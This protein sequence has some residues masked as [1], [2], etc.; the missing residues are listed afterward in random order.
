MENRTPPR[1]CGAACRRYLLLEGDISSRLEISPIYEISPPGEGDISFRR[2]Y[3]LG[4]RR[5]LLREEISPHLPRELAP[6]V[7]AQR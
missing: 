3:L 2:R 1:V 6:L 5:Y 7:T 4:G